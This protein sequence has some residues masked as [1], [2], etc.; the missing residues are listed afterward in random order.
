[1]ATDVMSLTAKLSLDTSEYEAALRAAVSAGQNFAGNLGSVSSGLA[2]AQGSAGASASAMGEAA[3]QAATLGAA[4]AQAA[5]N[6]DDLGDELGETAQQSEEFGEQAD[7]GEDSARRFGEQMQKAT[8]IGNLMS[9]AIKKATGA[10]VDFAK[11]SIG[12]GMSFDSSMSQVAATMG[13][14]VD[15]VQ[16]LRDFAQD[17][18]ASTAFSATQAADA[19]NYMALAGYDAEKSMSMLPNVLNLAASGGM[20]LATASDM[21][22]DAQSALGLSMDETTELVNKMAKTASSSNTSVSQLGEAMLQIGGSAK[23]LKG[24]TT[25]LTTILGMLA[26][27]GMKGAEGGT[28]LRNMLTSLMSPTKDA[29]AM[30]EQL[31]VSLYDSEGNMR[32]LNDVFID[33]RNGMDSLATQ[34][35]RDQVI[36]SIFNAR[37]MKAA[38]AMISN[39]GDRYE[40]LSGKID[41]AAGAAQDMA[42]TQL[43]NLQGDITLFKS[44]V[45]GAQIAVSDKLTP[46]LRKFTQFGSKAVSEMSKGFGRNGLAGA[47]EALHL[48]IS[49]QFGG[50]AKAIFA[51]ESATKGAI[52]AFITYKAV[53]KGIAITETIIKTVKAIKA[54]TTAQEALNAVTALNPY[55][56]IAAAI[57]AAGVAL[58]SFIDAQTDAIDVAVDGA[59]ALTEAQKAALD[60]INETTE[61]LRNSTQERQERFDSLNEEA[62]TY[63]R[64]KDELYGLNDV[65]NKNE[66]QKARMAAIVDVL[67]SSI[68]GLNLLYDEQTGK[69]ESNKQAVDKL[70][71]SYVEEARMQAAK[72][73]L[74]ELTKQQIEA[75]KSY[76]KASSERNKAVYRRNELLRTQERLNR[77]ISDHEN[78]TLDEVN[79]AQYSLSLVNKELDKVNDQLVET[80]VAYLGASTALKGINGEIDDMTDILGK[81]AEEIQAE[82]EAIDDATAAAAEGVARNTTLVGNAAEAFYD[83]VNGITGITL[84]LNDKVVDLSDDQAT[85]IGELID[86]YDE[87]VA[88]QKSAIESSI[89]FFG[90][91]EMTNAG[92]DTMWKNLDETATGLTEWATAVE[93]LESRDISGDLLQ[94][95]KDMGLDSYGYVMALYHASDE[96]LKQYSTLWDSTKTSVQDVTNRMVAG[97]KETIESQLSELAGIPNSHIEDFREAYESMGIAADEGYAKGIKAKMEEAA[98]AGTDIGDESID[99]TAEAIDAHSPSKRFEWLGRY[100]AEGFALG[101]ND[102]NAMSNISIA[103]HNIAVEAINSVMETLD[104][105]SP[106]R[107]LRKI[108]GFFSE[109]FALG[110]DDNAEMAEKNARM[111]A[112]T[113]AES[114][115]IEPE[116]GLAVATASASGLDMSENATINLS[117]D[118][119][120]MATVLAP[121]LDVIN[122]RNIVLATRG[123]QS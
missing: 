97:Q 118:G 46:S 25:E 43:D 4:A 35:E 23:K 19:L 65:E 105:H 33:L 48:A 98:K 16:E 66:A 52:A 73:N 101:L 113:A 40:E 94:E 122:G 55:A 12:V 89:N 61:A 117:V 2:S 74:V 112:E 110:I 24:G 56:A 108:G 107:V 21:I 59:E 57:V 111:M 36:T 17:M 1:M 49:E 88:K 22:T 64:L 96:Q 82:Q 90:G 116:N 13:V 63:L 28:H 30:M 84:S 7:G 47:L 81:S 3:Q 62:D 119:K 18:G 38:E 109:G 85:V 41:D 10:I 6:A 44:A 83:T 76:N 67:N 121:L 29:T 72:E 104:A 42:N 95:L 100:A 79:D 9:S 14:T 50:S 114:T 31:G 70:I 115:Y 80:D 91:F 92:F 8:I 93:Q 106:S 34:A 99:A 58:K 69:L 5:A 123:R 51:V 53:V 75:E 37:D 11:Q 78:R 71:D 87:L 32:S 60:G 20:D 77:I 45:E 120:L 26:D 39:V 102:E 54:A 27:N 86:T 68:E 15:K 103:A